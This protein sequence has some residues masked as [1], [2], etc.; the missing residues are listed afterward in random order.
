MIASDPDDPT[1]REESSSGPTNTPNARL[2]GRRGVAQ[3]ARRLAAEPRCRDCVARGRTV[4]ATVPDH[5]I[6]LSQGGT[7]TDD[8]IR[9]LCGD[10]HKIRTA[11]QLGH[12]VSQ[13]SDIDGRPLALDHPW[14]RKGEGAGQKSRA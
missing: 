10:C 14:N 1:Q 3:R 8:N 5:I 12:S 9:C 6:P 4:A 2:R 11:E 13:G 7:D